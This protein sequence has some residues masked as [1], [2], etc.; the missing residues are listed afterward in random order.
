MKMSRSTQRNRCL[1]EAFFCKGIGAGF[2]PSLVLLLTVIGGL[3]S[4]AAHGED[5]DWSSDFRIEGC[6][7]VY[8][9]A[10]PGELWIEVEKQDLNRI[11]R[12]THVRAIFFGPD[13]AVLAETY[14]PF[15][16]QEKGSGAAS[17]QRHRFSV[18]VPLKGVYGVNI[19]A[20]EDRYGQDMVWGIRTNSP[21]YLVETSR[22][23]KDERHQEPLVLHGGDQPGAVCFVPRNEALTLDVA[24]FTGA[25]LQLLDAVGGVIAVIPVGTDGKG[26]YTVAPSEQRE[27]VPWQ[28]SFSKAQG[29]INIDGVTRWDGEFRDLSLWSPRASTWFPFYENRWLLTPY[30][31]RRNVAAGE[32]G[33]VQF[34]LHNNGPASKEVA[35]DLVFPDGQSLDCSLSADTV[36]MGPGR[37]ASVRVR[38]VGADVEGQVHL[39]ATTP[40]GFTTW[41]TL[42]VIPGLDAVNAPLDLPLVLQPYRHENAQF[43][44]APDYPVTEEVYFDNDNRPFILSENGIF[45]QRDGEWNE[46]SVGKV[47]NSKIAFDGENDIYMLATS[48]GNVALEHSQ[49]GGKTFSSTAVPGKGAIELEQF[50]GHN[51]PDGPPPIVRYTRTQVDPKLK[52]RRVHDL[53]LF[54]PTKNADGTLSLGE[55]IRLSESCIGISSHSGI[56]STIASRGSKVHVTWGEATEPAVTVPGVPTYVATYDRDSG[57]LSEPALVGYG[58]PA[59]DVHNTPSITMDSQGYLHVLVG[60]HG[61]TFLYARSLAPND[62]GSGWTEPEPL[63]ADLRQTYVGFVCGPDDTLHVVFRLWN[64]DTTYFPASLYASLSYMEKKPGEPWSAPRPLVVSAFSEYSVFYHRLTIDR[65]GSLFLSYDYWPTYWFYRTDR[66]E[67]RRALMT[68]SSGGTDWK[69][70]QAADWSVD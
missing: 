66:R 30:T 24:G 4:P 25:E 49:D 61:S 50:S 8:V 53:D 1:H 59:N 35:L 27:N 20:S 47:V 46:T 42:R 31:Q 12:K 44:Y 52:W 28:L 70:V 33:E 48:D 16:G 2:F 67:T 7:G 63:G 11:G 29:T 43:G 21:R 26:Q 22:G 23:H 37:S 58:P 55:P 56:P 45:T 39:R 13:R 57:I 38:F 15:Q 18:D 64:S 36:T 54:V 9:L 69:L 51:R 17:V 65:K 62:A 34:E 32:S 14:L 3:L 40:S 68:S 10:E 6:G 41:S 5:L 19:T 60:T